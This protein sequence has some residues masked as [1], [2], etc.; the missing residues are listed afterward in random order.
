[1]AQEHLKLSYTFPDYGCQRLS[2]RNTPNRGNFTFAQ[3]P[4]ADL[5]PCFA[6]QD[7]EKK[8][9]SLKR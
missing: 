6:C 5:T 7:E 8:M 4:K 9:K 3:K 1:M 2:L